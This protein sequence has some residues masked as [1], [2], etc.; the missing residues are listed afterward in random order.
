M[1]FVFVKFLGQDPGVPAWS[2]PS[3][4]AVT[5]S[6]VVVYPDMRA[7]VDQAIFGSPTV[8]GSGT[9]PLPTQSRCV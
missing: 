4:P 5:V 1:L 8:F 2:A 9:T 3:I 7:A 6:R